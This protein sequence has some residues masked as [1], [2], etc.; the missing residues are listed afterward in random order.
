MYLFNTTT[1][2]HNP[3]IIQSIIQNVQ[4]KYE[5]KDKELKIKKLLETEFLSFKLVEEFEKKLCYFFAGF[6]FDVVFLERIDAFAFS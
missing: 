3:N 4:I 1:A 5:L 6:G 2:R